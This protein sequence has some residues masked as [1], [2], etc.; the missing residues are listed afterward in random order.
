MIDQIHKLAL[1]LTLAGV[2][3]FAVMSTTGTAQATAVTGLGGQVFATGGNVVVEVLASSSSFDNDIAFFFDFPDTASSHFIGIDDHPGSVD[4]GA[5]GFHFVSG[6]ELVF[7]IRSPAR[8]GSLF[9]MGGAERNADSKTHAKV[10]ASPAGTGFVEAWT[11]GFEDLFG[12]GDH[13]FDDAVIRISQSGISRPV[14][15]PVTVLLLG[16]GFA[17][18]G[19]LG[20]RPASA[21]G[22]RAP[23]YI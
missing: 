22:A 14:P 21:P 17:G 9:L 15:E 5:G 12:G 11:V 20:A 2:A 23:R 16:L 8:G 1:R 7:G 4:L 3:S 6:E 18:F 13:D 19:V 10:S